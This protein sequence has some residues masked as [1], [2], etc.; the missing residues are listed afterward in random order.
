[1]K[2]RGDLKDLIVEKYEKAIEK[3]F[4]L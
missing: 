3:E 4:E 2:I 1:M